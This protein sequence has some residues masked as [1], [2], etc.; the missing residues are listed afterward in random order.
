MTFKTLALAGALSLFTF[1]SAAALSLDEYIERA[2]SYEE[3]Y[4]CWEARYMRPRKIEEI[5]LRNEFARDQGLITEQSSQWGIRNGF[6]PI[7][8][9]FSR[10]RIHLICYISHSKPI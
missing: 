3:R 5:R 2:T 4:Q 7:V 1:E 9:F 6:Y 10:D 8:D